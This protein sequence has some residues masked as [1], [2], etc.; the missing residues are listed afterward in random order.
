MASIVG[1]RRGAAKER[2]T[3]ASM[4]RSAAPRASIG[5]SKT[6]RAAAPRVRYGGRR[7]AGSDELDREPAPWF[8]ETIDPT[9]GTTQATAAD[10]N[11]RRISS[12]VTGA[13]A[14]V[15]GR[16]RAVPAQ[17]RKR[18]RHPRPRCREPRT[19]NSATVAG[20]REAANLLKAIEL[21][22]FGDIFLTEGLGVPILFSRWSGTAS[23]ARRWKPT[24]RCAR[25]CGTIMARATARCRRAWRKKAGSRLQR[26]RTG[27][28]SPQA[29]GNTLSNADWL[30]LE[31]PIKL[32]RALFKIGTTHLAY[33]PEHADRSRHGRGRGRADPSGRRRRYGDALADPRKSPSTISAKSGLRR[34]RTTPAI[35]PPTKSITRV[36]S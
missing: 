11:C 35:W 31:R 20:K 10:E 14:F 13:T 5:D 19:P 24:R 36:N 7:L 29:K 15:F 28:A 25:S 34:P 4:T 23:T 26:P 8:A 9:T 16:E 18:L 33:K 3:S 30:K 6:Q 1:L 32:V 27:D 12:A 17:P 2:R 21:P 22:F